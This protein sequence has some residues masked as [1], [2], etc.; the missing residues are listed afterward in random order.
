[1]A[2]SLLQKRLLNYKDKETKNLKANELFVDFYIDDKPYTKKL[3]ELYLK[4][5]R[6]NKEFARPVSSYE[7]YVEERKK[8]NVYS[9][10]SLNQPLVPNGKIPGTDKVN[11]TE[12][13][14]KSF[15]VP[16]SY[17]STDNLTITKFVGDTVDVETTEIPFGMSR[18][19]KVQEGEVSG[20]DTFLLVKFVGSSKQEF[21]KKSDI[22]YIDGASTKR[23][24]SN[25]QKIN[26]S[27]LKNKNLQVGNRLIDTLYSEK[28][29]SFGEYEKFETLN[30]QDLQRKGYEFVPTL[31]EEER[32]DKK[33]NGLT[34]K[35]IEE[36]KRIGNIEVI[37]GKNYKV[38]SRTQDDKYYT[39]QTHTVITVPDP[40]KPGK[41]KQ[42]EYYAVKVYEVNGNGNYIQLKV[43]GGYKADMID[44]SSLCDEA[45]NPI[46]K[47]DIKNYVGKSI[48][49]K[50]ESGSILESENLTFEQANY[51]YLKHYN[52]EPSVSSADFMADNS[53]LQTKTG[54]FIEETKIRPIGY[55]FTDKKDECDVYL[56]KIQTAEGLLNKIINVEDYAKISNKYKVEEV[57]GLKDCAFA[58][59]DVIQNT[60]NAKNNKGKLEDCTV[61]KNYDKANELK[62]EDLKA[63]KETIFQKFQEAYANGQYNI[64]HV[65]VDG[66]RIELDE[67]LKRYILTDEHLMKDY[68]ADTLRY[69]GLGKSS[70]KYVSKDGKLGKFEGNTKLN[71]GKIVKKAYG[72][73][74]K[75]LVYYIGFSL[76]GAGMIAA[77]AAPVVMGAAAAAILAAPV[78]I[79]P[80]TGIACLFANLTRRPFKDKTKFNRK[81]WN[82]EVEKELVAINGNMKDTDMSLG[83][84]KDVFLAKMSRLKS[85]I[86]ASS[87]STVGD[88]FRVVDG[89]IVVDS[90]NVNDV[91][92][93]RKI[94]KKDLKDLKANKAKVE[95][96]KRLFEKLYKPFKAQEEKGI[97]P[98]PN[99][100]RYK[101]ALE[102]K[103]TW[104]D[105]QSEYENQENHFNKKMASFNS[106]V[107]PKD[108]DKGVGGKLKRADRLEKFWLVKKF[109][110]KEELGFENEDEFNKF[111]EN[112]KS[113][114]YDP[115]KDV[116]ITK[117]GEYVADTCKPKVQLSTEMVIIPEAQKETVDLLTKL[118][119]LMD[120]QNKPKEAERPVVEEEVVKPEEDK[121]DEEILPEP[122]EEISKK[123]ILKPIY[124]RFGIKEESITKNGSLRKN[125]ANLEFVLES[126]KKCTEFSKKDKLKE[127]EKLEYSN[128]KKLIQANEKII[129]EAINKYPNS[130]NPKNVNSKK[131]KE[132][133]SIRNEFIEAMRDS[134]NV[135]TAAGHLEIV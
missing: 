11:R 98:N 71:F 53:Y 51:L 74:A 91:M 61:L 87:K 95:R 86:L 5:K 55:K 44:I 58:D 120:K 1:M 118:K 29:Y 105:L 82:K 50:T 75:S 27:T 130:N 34:L 99:N 62:E 43:K 133:N 72:L 103:Q 96:A 114:M 125:K 80:I 24:Y 47:E 126:M 68:A 110:S 35:E 100:K 60:T 127:E 78:L 10:K 123:E 52:Y 79:P 48:K 122:K 13:Y 59:A 64:D 17:T 89:E 92:K 54:E 116:F 12:P 31:T 132:I 97:L 38:V 129:E 135:V 57:H 63:L 115:T 81:K 46:Q 88:S 19:R 36:Q 84:S 37:N 121:K 124:E 83:Y 39:E 66:K 56:I 106:E 26:F 49:I 15:E 2:T 112:L 6:G 70:I 90:E 73:W 65:Y 113:V 8:N 117:D 134:G 85:D 119:N 16:D 23:I 76:T 104:L 21:V 108:K 67:R 111:K 9:E 20:D 22:F 101:D 40:K 94:H 30:A 3:S 93:F 33:K 7:E 32:K 69:T 4:V 42:E 14:Y 102:A 25:G 18:T 45:G 77:L 41:T 131:F 28:E 109:A 128:L 107:K